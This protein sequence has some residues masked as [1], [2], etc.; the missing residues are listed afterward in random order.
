MN[1][2]PFAGAL[3][4]LILAV[5]HCI[6]TIQ[7]ERK[8]KELVYSQGSIY[9]RKFKFET[10]VF[11]RYSSSFFFLSL[12]VL[13]LHVYAE[14]TEGIHSYPFF[15]GI[16]IPCIFL[17]GPFI[18]IF[19][20]EMS[21]G[22]YYKIPILHFIPSLLSLL[23][24]FIMRPVNYELPSMDLHIQ[25]ISSSF[26]ISI[27]YLLSLGVVS[28]FCYTLWIS[29]RVFR[30]RFGS[31]EKLKSSF[32]PFLWLLIYSFFVVT[33]FV[34]SQLFFMQMFFVAC[35]GL[36]SLLA[37]ILLLKTNHR[38]IIPNFK[39][40]TRFAR[41][42]E[43][44]VNGINIAQV[45]QRLDDLMN[46]EQLYLNDNLTLPI[47]SK[48]LDLSTHQLSEI[49]NSHLEITFRNYVNQFRLMEAARLLLERPDMT[50]LSIIYASGFNS[51]SSFHKLFQNRF[52]LSPQNYRLQSH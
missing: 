17:I 40:E 3:V 2:I 51:K 30:W 49:L 27:Q 28:I 34:I 37:F 35:L 50:I 24:I 21:G 16:H 39:T 36:S 5:S 23:Y 52:G 7:K 15:Y 44:R 18:Y 48:R 45:L 43:S 46:L 9:S 10:G 22:E 31:K 19:F 12:S 8:R 42:K 47:L 41:Y 33:L 1:L 25:N 38:E 14:L 11:Y 32:G 20:D 6:E 13:Q 4:A 29:I 26:G